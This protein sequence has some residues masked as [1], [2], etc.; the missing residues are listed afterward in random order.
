M[1]LNWKLAEPNTQ[2]AYQVAAK[3]FETITGL[4]AQRADAVSIAR[5]EAS[6]YERGLKVNTI[7]QRL[8]AVSVISGVKVELP[9][10]EKTECT[11]LSADQ[12]KAILAEVADRADRMLMV[13]LL[14]IGT[15]ARKVELAASDFAAHF[16]GLVKERELS[17]Q[18]VTRRLKRYA[19]KAGIDSDL[20]NL[21][22]FCASG[23]RLL[24]HLDVKELVEYFAPVPFSASDT[25]VSRP[26]H[27]I[28][29]RSRSMRSA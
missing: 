5:W 28:G 26:L 12:V 10:R 6:M 22:V 24:K 27:G 29:R 9:K 3:D 7:R 17:A 19:R 8:S 20:V 1:T 23:R 16:L 4:A 21:R 18:D 25:L 15:R 13:R 11:W 2:R 14:T